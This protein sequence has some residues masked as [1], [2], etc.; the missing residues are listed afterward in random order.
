MKEPILNSH[1][2]AEYEPAHTAEHILNYSLPYKG[3]FTLI[4]NATLLPVLISPVG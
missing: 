2:K 3:K 4:G 1:N